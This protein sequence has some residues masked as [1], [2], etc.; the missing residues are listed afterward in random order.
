MTRVAHVT[1]DCQNSY[2]LLSSSWREFAETR[3]RLTP[4]PMIGAAPGPPLTPGT[5]RWS[6]TY[7][8]TFRYLIVIY[9]REKI[10]HLADTFHIHS[11]YRRIRID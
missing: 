2:S 9:R 6:P 11:V 7:F 4:A 8:I 10:R 3:T 1:A 5:H